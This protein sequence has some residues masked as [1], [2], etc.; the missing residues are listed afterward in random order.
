M[1]FHTVATDIPNQHNNVEMSV[2]LYIS[3]TSGL[4]ISLVFVN[5]SPQKAEDGL[6]CAVSGEGAIVL[7]MK[8]FPCNRYIQIC[9][10]PV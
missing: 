4:I 6:S 9:S 1:A 8:I 7:I 5:I 2:W 10:V 3:F